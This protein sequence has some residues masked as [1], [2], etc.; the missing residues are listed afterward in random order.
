MRRESPG[1][2][3]S[4]AG[5]DSDAPFDAWPL[6]M[7]ALDDAFTRLPTLDTSILGRDWAVASGRLGRAL[8]AV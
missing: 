8:D 2:T 4:A 3:L 7:I 1:H 6:D 5:V